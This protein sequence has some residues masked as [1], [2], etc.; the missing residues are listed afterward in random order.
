MKWNF[1]EC[2]QKR[3][4]ILKLSWPMTNYFLNLIITILFT[5][6]DISAHCRGSSVVESWAELFQHNHLWLKIAPYREAEV[7]QIVQ[8]V[9][10]NTTR[11]KPEDIQK[12]EFWLKQLVSEANYILFLVDIQDFFILF[13]RLDVILKCL[14]M[15]T[16]YF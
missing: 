5:I 2:E 13:V 9:V 10:H 4:L 14:H 11:C 15:S 3:V 8:I 6:W 7:S 1:T 12:W 16:V